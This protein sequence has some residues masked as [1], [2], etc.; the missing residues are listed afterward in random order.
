MREQKQNVFY[1]VFKKKTKFNFLDMILPFLKLWATINLETRSKIE[2][3][4]I[5]VVELS[6]T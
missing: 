3:S 4:I 5:C 1:S 2:N 6:Y